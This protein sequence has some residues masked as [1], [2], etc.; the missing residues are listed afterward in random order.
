MISY[1]ESNS[2]TWAGVGHP[3]DTYKW[4]KWIFQQ[5]V[6]ISNVAEEGNDF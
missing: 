1:N 3:S 2:L 5:Y 6:N 4:T